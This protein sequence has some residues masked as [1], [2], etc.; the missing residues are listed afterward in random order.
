M[1]PRASES[2]GVYTLTSTNSISSYPAPSWINRNTT[3]RFFLA[4]G[5]ARIS[6]ECQYITLS[7][8]AAVVVNLEDS[9]GS[10]RASD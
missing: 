3:L 9:I 7:T 2:G 5:S 1:L 6:G 8:D 4:M 10:T